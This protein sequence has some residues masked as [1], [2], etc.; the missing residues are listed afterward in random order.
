MHRHIRGKWGRASAAHQRAKDAWCRSLRSRRSS[1][2][3][4][5]RWAWSHTRG[6]R[7]S[8]ATC[9]IEWHG[10]KEAASSC[11]DDAHTLG[12][13]QS[14]KGHFRTRNRQSRPTLAR[15]LG[16]SFPLLSGATRMQQSGQRKADT[17]LKQHTQLRQHFMHQGRRQGFDL[18]L[19]SG[20]QVKYTRLIAAK[21]AGGLD[22]VHNN[23]KTQAPRKIATTGDGQHHRKLGRLVELTRRNHKNGAA[24]ALLMACCRVQ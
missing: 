17:S 1:T 23:G 15:R 6:P 20:D 24:A 9:R 8:W 12:G 5:P 16:P 10:P 18:A 19:A 3:V 7:S 22:T 2:R 14:A 21:N 13:S 11:L 4:C